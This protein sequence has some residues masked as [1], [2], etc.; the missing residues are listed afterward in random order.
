MLSM[1]EFCRGFSLEMNAKESFLSSENRS[2][3]ILDFVHSY[4]CWPMTFSSL[5]GS[6]LMDETVAVIVT[7]WLQ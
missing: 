7:S 6:G 1:M 4:M 2:K 3:G 5:S